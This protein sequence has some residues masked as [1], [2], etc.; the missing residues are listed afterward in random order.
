[1]TP[2]SEQ[3]TVLFNEFIEKTRPSVHQAKEYQSGNVERFGDRENI[4]VE[5]ISLYAGVED[6]KFKTDSLHHFNPN[7]VIFPV[8]N[9]KKNTPKIHGI[10]INNIQQDA[11]N[12]IDFELA[13]NLLHKT[14]NSKLSLERITLQHPEANPYLFSQYQ[15][16]ANS[17]LNNSSE[18]LSKRD[19]RQL[20]RI[21]KG[22]KISNPSIDLY[23]TFRP[24]TSTET[25]NSQTLLLDSSKIKTAI[26]NGKTTNK[27]SYIDSDGTEHPIQ[28]YN[29][30]ILN[31]KLIFGNP[32]G[33]VF[34]GRMQDMSPE[35][36]NSL[37]EYLSKNPS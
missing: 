35:Q 29:A 14:P 4:P 31:K 16:H 6:G 32:E 17:I 20:K 21:T 36:L 1:M 25:S 26:E 12:N 27:F 9:V 19:V 13:Y 11:R 22:K 2:E 30:P 37:N 15:D 3:S 18:D 10:Q 34:I 5:N 7:T 33:G 8:R 23:Q 28:D 24:I